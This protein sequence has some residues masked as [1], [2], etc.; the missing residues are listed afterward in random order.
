[1]TA[2]KVCYVNKSKSPRGLL[3]YKFLYLLERFKTEKKRPRVFLNLMYYK[4]AIIPRAADA[5]VQQRRTQKKR[6]AEAVIEVT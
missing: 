1:M 5:E 6:R 2:R 3:F 4:A